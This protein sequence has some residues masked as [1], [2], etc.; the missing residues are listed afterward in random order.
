[1]KTQELQ[2]GWS[3][4]TVFFK[5]SGDL[6]DRLRPTC[7]HPF[8]NWCD[9]GEHDRYFSHS[10]PVIGRRFL[11]ILL[12]IVLQFLDFPPLSLSGRRGKLGTRQDETASFLPCPSSRERLKISAPDFW[13]DTNDKR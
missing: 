5:I 4:A 9:H 13:S 3:L 10:A 8:P 12:P 7:R 2:F 11:V 6:S 1:M